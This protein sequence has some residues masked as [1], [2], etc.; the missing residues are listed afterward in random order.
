MQI[1]REILQ[2]FAE[3]ITRAVLSA[4][5]M[6]DQSNGS[7]YEVTVTFRSPHGAIVIPVRV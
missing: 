1:D 3:D 7:I 2:L 5:K 6:I 4:Q